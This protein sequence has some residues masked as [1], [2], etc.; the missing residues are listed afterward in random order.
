MTAHAGRCTCGHVR[1]RLLADPMIV[2]C[3]HCTWCRRET[4]SAFV[5]NAVIETSAVEI[6][7]GAVETVLTPSASGA[8][9]RIDRCPTCRTAVWSVYAGAGPAIRFV[10]V[11]T[12]DEAGRFPPDVHIFAASALPWLSLPTPG[13]RVFD[14]FYAF[15]DVWR[16]EALARRRAARG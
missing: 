7:A 15:E 10:R 9:Q 12:L 1:Y 3:C 8:G 4:G 6:E 14:A 16:P 5:L 2:H 11:G 13:S